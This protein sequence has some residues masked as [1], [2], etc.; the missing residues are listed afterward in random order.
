MKKMDV[1]DTDGQISGITARF[2]TMNICNHL[3]HINKTAPEDDL[4]GLFC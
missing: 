4:P 3:R 1:P 2:H